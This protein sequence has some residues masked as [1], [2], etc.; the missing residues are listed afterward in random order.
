MSSEWI[1]ENVWG[2]SKE[3]VE[4]E[5]E[6]IATDAKETHRL[7]QLEDEGNDPK[8]TQES[9]INGQPRYQ[10]SFPLDEDEHE[11][12]KLGRPKERTKY[13][14]DKHVRDRDPLGKKAHLKGRDAD[15]TIKHK[16]KGRS[17][18]AKTE[19]AKGVAKTI[20]KSMPRNSKNIIKETFK[21]TNEVEPNMLDEQNLMD[22]G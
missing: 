5:K 12:G 15:R 9:F 20:T 18:L 17:P 6:K 13:N 19:A 14:T 3:E 22:L 11:E 8:V 16:Y 7:T 10:S 4:S 21:I 1:F 2:M